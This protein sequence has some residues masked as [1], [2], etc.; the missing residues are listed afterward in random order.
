MLL[1]LVLVLDFVR[2]ILEKP[3]KLHRS[4]PITSRRAA[5]LS[6][7]STINST[8][9]VV[10][11]V[12]EEMALRCAALDA[13]TQCLIA[14]AGKKTNLC[15]EIADALRNA[16]DGLHRLYKAQRTKGTLMSVHPENNP[17]GGGDVL[18]TEMI[19]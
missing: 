8:G 1:W 17:E 18:N 12:G 3:I 11:V 9:I 4:S 15:T 13:V 10:E 14:I 7:T 16:R 19:L 2:G 5:M 6:L